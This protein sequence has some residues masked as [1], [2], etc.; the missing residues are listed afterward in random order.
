VEGSVLEAQL[1]AAG[2]DK[3]QREIQ[4]LAPRGFR[5]SDWIDRLVDFLATTHP[6]SRVRVA[7]DHLYPRF[8]PGGQRVLCARI[9]LFA[10]RKKDEIGALRQI[11]GFAAA[12]GMT[13]SIDAA[14]AAVPEANRLF[15]QERGALASTSR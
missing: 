11:L 1:D 5:P 4:I 7:H 2:L 15:L 3:E 9:E 12:N 10:S 6:V 13:A 8:L 14:C